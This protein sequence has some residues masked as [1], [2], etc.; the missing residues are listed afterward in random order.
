[1]KIKRILII[2]L[3]CMMLMSTI[4]FAD[5][6]PGIYNN[7]LTPDTGLS[8]IGDAILGIIRGI[9]GTAA[10][11]SVI[12]LG[13]R[14]TYSAP[15]DKAEVKKKMMPVVIGSILLFGAMTIV[16]VLSEVAADLF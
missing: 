9:A 2:F 15:G 10:A 6:P 8:G 14:Y 12:V 7:G 5:S 3:V 4:I 11:V 16:D 13:I 1:M